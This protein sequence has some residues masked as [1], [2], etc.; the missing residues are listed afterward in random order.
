[1]LRVQGFQTFTGDVGVI[2]VVD[3]GVAEQ[4]LDHR[5]SAPWLSKWVAKAWRST[6]RRQLL[7]CDAGEQR[8]ASLINCQKASASSGRRGQ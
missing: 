5:R 2:W 4:Q 8:V 3:V 7:R 6:V 1:M